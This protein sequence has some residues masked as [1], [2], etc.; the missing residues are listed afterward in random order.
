MGL[1]ME[2]FVAKMYENDADGNWKAFG[3]VAQKLT[4]VT[5]TVD[6]IYETSLLSNPDRPLRA[7]PPMAPGVAP[8]P[9]PERSLSVLEPE[10]VEQIDEKGK[11]YVK[12][13]RLLPFD[14]YFLF[15]PDHYYRAD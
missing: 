3:D 2:Q 5:H 4:W 12:L 10:L 15:D 1:T 13:P 6:R 11:A 9:A 8:A 7:F 14:C